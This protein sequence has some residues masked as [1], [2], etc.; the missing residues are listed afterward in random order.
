MLHF[1]KRVVDCR[2]LSSPVRGFFETSTMADGKQQYKIII[3]E[4]QSL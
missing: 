2:R 1:S 4:R 3:G